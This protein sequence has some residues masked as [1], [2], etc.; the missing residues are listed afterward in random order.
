[1]QTTQIAGGGS[2]EAAFLLGLIPGVGAIY[3]AEYIKAAV[4]LLV[5][6][7]MITLA[8]ASYG[9]ADAL[10]G[11]LAFGFYVYMPFEA[12]YTAKKRK[13]AKEGINLITPFDNFSEQYG[14]MELWGGIAL[15]ALG[16]I[17]LLHTFNIISLERLARLWPALLIVAGL[18]II[19]RF[20]K[21]NRA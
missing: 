21:G 1:V 7:T 11:L 17:F 3:N 4:H 10:W 5:F 14:D 9:P 6:G 8:N 13:L 20:M 15:V 16:S 2:P 18:A 19:R 12:Y